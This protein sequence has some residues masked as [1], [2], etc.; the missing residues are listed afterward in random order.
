MPVTPN[1]A[2]VGPTAR[3]RRRCG[4]PVACA[5]AKVKP[6]MSVSEPVPAR[7]R[8]A[9]LNRWPAVETGA[10]NKVAAAL[11]AEPKAFVTVTV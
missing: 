6:T 3:R 11:V 1:A 5:A 10:T 2:S 4:V 8:M 9:R 7:L